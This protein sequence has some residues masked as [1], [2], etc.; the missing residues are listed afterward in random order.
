MSNGPRSHSKAGFGAKSMF[1]PLPW[2][3][4]H[5]PPQKTKLGFCPSLPGR[6]LGPKTGSSLLLFTEGTD[7]GAAGVL[8]SSG[9]HPLTKP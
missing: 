4:L 9:L 1:C 8:P 3:K 5:V 7:K 2:Q 6:G